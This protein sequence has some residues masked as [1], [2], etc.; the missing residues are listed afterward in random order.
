[1]KIKLNNKGFSTMEIL[2]M[3][4]MISLMLIGG[5]ALVVSFTNNSKRI[6]FRKDALT[7]ISIAKNAFINHNRNADDPYV[8]RGEN[9]TKAFCVTINGLLANGYMSDDYFKDFDGYVVVE[10][11]GYGLKYSLRLTNKDM[12][13]DGYEEAKISEEKNLKKMVTKYKDEDF[14]S[15]VGTSFTGVTEDKGGTGTKDRVM[16]YE[17]ICLNEKVE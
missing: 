10:D 11:D 14:S 17:G 6:N 1:M 16:T 5:L 7:V 2:F 4:I 15:M 8:I 9:E 13:I 12:V 3:V